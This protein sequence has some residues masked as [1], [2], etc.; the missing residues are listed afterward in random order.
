MIC[1]VLIAVSPLWFFVSSLSQ[2]QVPTMPVE[3]HLCHTL[4]SGLFRGM[5]LD[6]RLKFVGFLSLVSLQKFCSLF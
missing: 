3:T 2:D 6:L 4:S 5:N 1:F